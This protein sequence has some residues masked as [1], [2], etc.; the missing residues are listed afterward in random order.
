VP[1]GRLFDCAATRSPSAGWAKFPS[2]ICC[3]E[4]HLRRKSIS[5][6][7]SFDALVLPRILCDSIISIGPTSRFR[8]MATSA[9][10]RHR[11]DLHATVS[12]SMMRGDSRAGHRPGPLVQGLC[13][14]A[15]SNCRALCPGAFHCGRHAGNV[16]VRWTESSAVLD[17]GIVGRF[18]TPSTQISFLRM[19]E[20]VPRDESAMPELSGT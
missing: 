11:H 7:G 17:W 3:L 10:A 2:L 18:A 9:I 1:C 20:G 8:S 4:E 12:R 5:Q 19:I 15:W 16:M 14:K 13:V 6:R